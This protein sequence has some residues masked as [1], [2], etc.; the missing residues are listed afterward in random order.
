MADT[1][2]DVVDQQI[3]IIQQTADQSIA[4]AKYIADMI[5]ADFKKYANAFNPDQQDVS[6]EQLYLGILEYVR[7]FDKHHSH[8]IGGVMSYEKP[9][10]SDIPPDPDIVLG[11]TTYVEYGENRVTKDLTEEGKKMLY[12]YR[13]ALGLVSV[14]EQKKLDRAAVKTFTR[15]VC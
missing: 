5:K 10:N 4:A 1:I 8:A 3:Q 12:G 13:S 9:N 11:W 14:D 15:D 7:S 6:A 2:D